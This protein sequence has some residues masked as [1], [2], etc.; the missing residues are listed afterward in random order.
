LS[1]NGAAFVLRED[2]ARATVRPKCDPFSTRPIATCHADPVNEADRIL[3]DDWRPPGQ[4]RLEHA[5]RNHNQHHLLDELQAERD[6]DGLPTWELHRVLD[7]D[8]W[9]EVWLRPV[10]A[11]DPRPPLRVGGWPLA[12]ETDDLADAEAVITEHDDPGLDASA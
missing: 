7:A 11:L 12:D 9:A 2:N 5:W 3:G 1:E 4:R 6:Q 8:D 10:D